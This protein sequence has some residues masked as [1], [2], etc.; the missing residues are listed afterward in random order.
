MRGALCSLQPSCS[1]EGGLTEGFT[2]PRATECI[3]IE[4][5]A[6]ERN[7]FI[8]ESTLV[9]RFLI[10]RPVFQHIPHTMLF[11]YPMV[12]WRSWKCIYKPLKTF[13]QLGGKN[14]PSVVPKCLSGTGQ[15]ALTP[16]VSHFSSF[17]LGTVF[18]C[19]CF[20]SLAQSPWGSCWPKSGGRVNGSH[21]WIMGVF[22]ISRQMTRKA[23][24]HRKELESNTEDSKQLVL[25]PV[26]PAGLVR[27]KLK[28][29]Q[30]VRKFASSSI[31]ESWNLHFFSQCKA[32][33]MWYSLW[34]AQVAIPSHNE[35][36]KV[37]FVIFCRFQGRINKVLWEKTVPF[38]LQPW[39]LSSGSSVRLRP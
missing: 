29:V 20:L 32:G 5:V 21:P 31:A 23:V 38:G 37:V 35:T 10:R 33:D 9:T 15:S 34:W 18:G 4:T 17:L 3:W 7:L 22:Y 27:Y 6:S 8:H 12:Y 13:T 1:R 26:W 24:M 39:V 11:F 19:G 30:K 2:W 28:F 16:T 25:G 14:T 36:L